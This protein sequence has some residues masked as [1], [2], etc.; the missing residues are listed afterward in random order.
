MLGYVSL[1]YRIWVLKFQDLQVNLPYFWPYFENFMTQ[2]KN[3]REGGKR[4]ISYLKSLKDWSSYT[5]IELFT[6]K[7]C[8]NCGDEIFV[9]FHSNF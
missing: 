7:P 2:E 1:P 3:K 9:V 4:R 6:T 5:N 8:E